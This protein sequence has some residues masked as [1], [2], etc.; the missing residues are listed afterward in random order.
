MITIEV[1]NKIFNFSLNNSYNDVIS[2]NK[3]LLNGNLIIV[4]YPEKLFKHNILDLQSY[5]ESL[6]EI[7]K[8]NTDLILITTGSKEEIRNII[9]ENFLQYEVLIDNGYKIYKKFGLDKLLSSTTTFVIKSN[10]ELVLSYTDK[11]NTSKL[12]PEEALD[13]LRNDNIRQNFK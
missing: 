13:G 4:F 10:G 12:S 3:L 6:P 5:Q 2:I 8:L 1:G 7:H 11:D 9:E